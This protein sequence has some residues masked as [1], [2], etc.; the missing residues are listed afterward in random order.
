MLVPGGTDD[1][2]T[3]QPRATNTLSPDR[4]KLWNAHGSEGQQTHQ[5]GKARHGE[6]QYIE[7]TG[8][9]EGPIKHR[10]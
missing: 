10:Q 7:R 8:H 9:R 1:F 6:C 2:Q 5:N 3:A 4:G